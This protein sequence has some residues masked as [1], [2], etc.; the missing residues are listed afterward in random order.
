MYYT[1]VKGWLKNMT[2]NATNSKH[3]FPQMNSA[4]TCGFYFYEICARGDELYDTMGFLAFNY[5]N[6]LI[7][8]RHLCS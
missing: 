7:C 3:P 6:C 2:I 5:R 8:L 1:K 4:L